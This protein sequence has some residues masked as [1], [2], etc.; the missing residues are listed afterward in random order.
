MNTKPSQTVRSNPNL[1]KHG[2]HTK[3]VHTMTRATTITKAIVL[4]ATL[5]L[6]GT[7]AAR[8]GTLELEAAQ[9]A[10]ASLRNQ[11]T[12]EGSP[13]ATALEDKKGNQD[14]TATEADGGSLT[15]TVG[16]VLGGSSS[17]GLNIYDPAGDTAG[18]C[19]WKNGFTWPAQTTLELLVKPGVQTSS[20]AHI[21]NR[22]ANPR[23][24]LRQVNHDTIDLYLGDGSGSVATILTNHTLGNTYYVA[25]KIDYDSGTGE[26]TVNAYYADVTAPRPAAGYPLTQGITNLV[27]N[28][29]PT[30]I[31]ALYFGANGSTTMLRWDGSLDAIAVYDSLL[32]L[33]T[34]QSH[35]NFVHDPKGTVVSVR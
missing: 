25:L 9:Q 17:Q 11:W 20:E 13:E 31:A 14:L 15:V 16:S 12:F 28:G 7:V 26:Q 23:F 27:V 8:A 30:G 24:Y 3:E 34:L 18:A 19:A 6:L 35:V 22:G 5:G 10:E 29:D 32:P 21:I 2:N 33:S 4:G 1:P